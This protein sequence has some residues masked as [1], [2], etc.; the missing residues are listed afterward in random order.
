MIPLWN[1]KGFEQYDVYMLNG[2]RIIGRFVPVLIR[3][4]VVLDQLSNLSGFS[5]N[6]SLLSFSLLS[7][8]L[9]LFSSLSL[10][11][12]F[13][14]TSLL[15]ACVLWRVLRVCVCFLCHVSGVEQCVQVKRING[16]LSNVLFLTCSQ[17]ENR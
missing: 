1:F 9:Y 5:F 14:S 10:F 8:H 6:L 17:T 2:T 7:S 13:M 16:G 15:F 11:V 3:A 12:C 4:S